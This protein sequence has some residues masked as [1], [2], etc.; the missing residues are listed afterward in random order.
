MEAGSSEKP[1]NNTAGDPGR[2]YCQ[3]SQPQV[4][5]T[6]IDSY[7]CGHACLKHISEVHVSAR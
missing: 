5:G 3:I 4:T 2:N 7:Q 6:R 1:R